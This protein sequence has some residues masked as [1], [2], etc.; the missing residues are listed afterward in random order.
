MEFVASIYCN[1]W[2][3]LEIKEWCLYLAINDG[4]KMVKTKFG[5]KKAIM[6]SRVK[7]IMPYHRNRDMTF[8]QG[9]KMRITLIFDH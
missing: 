9:S 4:K 6:L 3:T 7:N 1:I 8:D 2:E 5:H